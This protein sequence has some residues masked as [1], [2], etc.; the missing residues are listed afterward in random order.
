MLRTVRRV[1]RE[2]LLENADVYHFH[3]AEL[4]PIAM[5]LKLRGKKVV[6]DVHEDNSH[7]LRISYWIPRPVRKPVARCTS[8][9]EVFASRIL[10]GVVAATPAIAR[11]FPTSKTSVVQNFPLLS[12]FTRATPNAYQSRPE[13]VI[14]AGMM[15]LDRCTLEIIESINIVNGSRNA[16]SA[17]LVLAGN[18]VPPLT[19][20]QMEE[21]PGWEYTQFLGWRERSTVAELL[22]R[23]RIGLVVMQ[24][25]E[26]IME[27]QPTKLFEYMAAGIP[28]VASDFPVWRGFVESARCGILV[29]PSDVNAIAEAITW[30]LDHPEEA[31]AMG[32]RG[33]AAIESTVNWDNEAEVLLKFYDDIVLK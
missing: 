20:R 31:E 32:Q 14:Y 4:I 19:K 27:A 23:A 22:G 18:I 29:D 24:S 1:Y 7:T 11:R 15:S 26:H 2:A 8:V 16:T 21:L 9:L 28:V 30:L 25:L 6:Y 13:A 12:E 17:T 5:L 3:D 10:N 33:K